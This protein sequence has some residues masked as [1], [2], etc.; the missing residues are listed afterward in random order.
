MARIGLDLDGVCYR[1]VDAFRDY[2]HNYH[3]VPLKNMPPATRWEFY[4]DWGYTLD[5]YKELVHS[6]TRDASLFWRGKTY[7]KCK[8]VIDHLYRQGHEVIFVT[9]RHFKN[10]PKLA[11]YATTYWVNQV[12]G[13]PHHEIIF[14]DDKFQHGVDILFDDAPYQYDKVTQA[15]GNIVM[16]DQLWNMHLTE[17]E[18]VYGWDGVLQYV[19]EKYSK[20]VTNS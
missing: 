2:L 16:F 7:D 4:E 6:G 20:S 13:L 17:A 14:S 8:D 5:E 18:R 10:D 1:F 3:D 9:S 12:A 19:E 11:E 15:G